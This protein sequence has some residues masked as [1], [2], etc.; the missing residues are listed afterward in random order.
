MLKLEELS[1]TLNVI[2][3]G[4]GESDYVIV[5]STSL[6]KFILEAGFQI[7]RLSVSIFRVFSAMEEVEQNPTALG[8][9]NLGRV[10]ITYR[11]E[12]HSMNVCHRILLMQGR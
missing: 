5:V 3:I 8:K 11:V 7:D 4:M 9:D 12:N 6:G 2:Q 1:A 10:P